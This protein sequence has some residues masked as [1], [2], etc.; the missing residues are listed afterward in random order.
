MKTKYF[1]HIVYISFVSLFLFFVSTSESVGE[2]I[3]V[4]FANPPTSARPGVFWDWLNGNITKEGITRD[5][6]AMKS[7]GIMRAEIWDV[8]ALQNTQM[9]PV[10]KT[11]LGDESV[12]LIKHALAEGKR[13]GMRIGLIAASGW[14]AGGSWVAPDWA[15]KGLFFSELQIDG[16]AK[17]SVNLPFPNLPRNCP[18][19]KNGMPVFHK[20]VAVFAVPYT[21]DKRI[22]SIDQIINLTDNFANGQLD[23]DVPEGKWTIL[24]FVCSNTGQMLVVP[25]PNSNGLFIDFLDPEA[26]KRYFQYFMDRLGI[27]PG[28]A[29]ESGL[30]YLFLDSMELS[31]GIAWTNNMPDVFKKNQGYSIENYLPLLAGWKMQDIQNKVWYDFKKVI[32]DQFI[33]SHYVT[34][35]EFLK[36]YNIDLIAEAGGPGPPVWN[37]CPVDSLRALGNVSIPRGEFWIQHRNMF[38]VK[39]I[40][41]AA[42]IYGK[43]IV[44]AES[45]TTWR[46]WKDSPFDVKKY[47]DRAYGEGLN[48]I[49]FVS[50]AHTTPEDG[51]PGRTFHAG[52]DI[53]P[54]VTWWAKSQPF[55]DYISRCNYMLQQGLFVADVCYYYGDQTPNFFPAFHNVPAK[56]RLKGLDKGYDYDVVNSDV[57]L[58]RMSVKDGRIVL[59]NGMSYTLMMLPEQDTMPLAVLRKIENLV[60]AGATIIGTK[61]T[62]MP[63]LNISEEEQ[64]TFKLLTDQ[65]WGN[66]DV[67]G[68]IADNISATK[69]LLELGK[70][71]DFDFNGQYAIDYIHRTSDIGEIYFVYNESN[72][73]V[74]TE[75][76]FRVTGLYPEI[77][78]PA[79]SKQT[80]INHY[81]DSNGSTQ[82]PI[83]LP[84]YGSVFVVFNKQKRNLPKPENTDGL[85]RQEL[86]GLWK[87]N[88]PEGWGAPSEV[89]FDKL[90]S[91]TD[92]EDKGIKYFS[93]TATYNKTFTLKN[94]EAG[95]RY[96][97]DLG[98]VRDVA[99]IFVN[100]KSA[101]ILWKKPFCADISDLVHSGDNELKVEVVNLWVNRL[102]GDMLSDPKNRYCRTNHP[103]VKQNIGGGETYKEQPSGLLRP[104]IILSDK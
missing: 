1:L 103:Y 83:N 39:E 90:K 24:R 33:F 20:E 55:L 61:P 96:Y 99:E 38:L 76:R 101:G 84:P 22:E 88:F 29:V 17:I 27:T 82:F 86:S 54:T 80:G 70:G 53:N 62:K 74:K 49:T 36:K 98:E 102:T 34:G 3:A 2:D 47:I 43:K 89:I 51:L 92:F 57:L 93:G 15:S 48:D 69:T 56:P 104:V 71:K 6:E 97:I 77:W 5:L 18:R 81:K 12:D 26:T 44:D 35:T 65:L 100:G 9:I 91:W 59:P 87:V 42:H 23:W 13:L 40:S 58:N 95:K 31:N 67:K 37:T 50:F 21:A 66:S 75:L 30:A 60:V 72:E 32:S 19:N 46:R 41:S 52:Y 94:V 11:F 28:N 78:N 16:A 68:K 25:S 14:N 7:K 8:R 45:L 4:G 64:K 73:T 10:G 63:G 79:D 85:V